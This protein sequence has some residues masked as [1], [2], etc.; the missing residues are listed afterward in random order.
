MALYEVEM[1]NELVKRAVQTGEPTE[2]SDDWAETRYIE[3]NAR[4]EGDARRKMLSKYPK[5]KGFMIKSIM[6]A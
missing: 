6:P 3:V 5:D 4:D 1:Y 2:Y